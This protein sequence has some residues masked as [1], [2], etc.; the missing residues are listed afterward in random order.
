MAATA[1]TSSAHVAAADA[2]STVAAHDAAASPPI[3]KRGSSVVDL[4][5]V[6]P[7]ASAIIFRQVL[8]NAQRSSRQRRT[9]VNKLAVS[10]SCLSIIASNSASRFTTFSL[11]ATPA[12]ALNAAASGEAAA[13]APVVAAALLVAAAAR[14]TIFAMASQWNLSD[15]HSRSA[16]F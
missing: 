14:L 15:R 7:T 16:D 2:P 6:F 13:S 4:L 9:R 12:E 10:S 3:P 5:H 1:S 8:H 11:A